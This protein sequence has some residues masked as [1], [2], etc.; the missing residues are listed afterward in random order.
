VVAVEA[1]EMLTVSTG[2]T[3]MVIVFDKAGLP[4]G[5]ITLEVNSQDIASLL[6]GT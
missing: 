1:I 6:A 2:F 4:I 3:V 5:Q